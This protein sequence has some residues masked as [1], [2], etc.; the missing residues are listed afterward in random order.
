MDDKVFV[1]EI[2]YNCPICEEV[3]KV[4]VYKE[5]TKA[6][7]KKQPVEYIETYYYCPISEEEFYPSQVLNVNLLEARDSYR[8]NNNLLTSIEIKEIRKFYGLNQK[9]FS[10]IF[11]W[12]DI[13]IQ[14]Y[15]TKLIQEETYNEMIKRA[16]DD[17]LF[18][19]EELK[20]HK[21]KFEENRF[22]EIENLLKDEIR[23]KQFI[24][25]VIFHQHCTGSFT[26]IVPAPFNY[27]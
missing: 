27:Q 4:K 12:G 19:Y 14:R 9:E 15:E 5:P 17:P 10:N 7:V 2:K 6:L 21:D 18:L 26:N 13:T 8:K 23:N 25:F 11:G 22:N 20:K 24:H 1:E 3:H 16:K